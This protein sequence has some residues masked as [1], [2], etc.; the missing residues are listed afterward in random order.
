MIR[1]LVIGILFFLLYWLQ[2][3][4]YKHL[5]QK[6]LT[7]SVSF[8]KNR[9]FQGEQGELQEIIENKKHLPLA[10]LKVKFRA[11]RN[12]AFG[13]EKGSR[14]TD[15]FY[16]NDVFRIGGGERVIR[17]L[18][19]QGVRRGYYTIESADLVAADLL[20][21]TSFIHTTPVWTELYVYPR[22]YDSEELR[23]SLVRLSGEVLTKRQ[24]LED[25]FEYRGIREYL[26]FDSM[27]TINWKATAKTGELKVNR[28]NYTSPKHVRVFFSIQDDGS[29]MKD[30]RVEATLSIVTG[31]CSSFLS[32]GLQVSCYGNGRD[33]KTD[34]YV[35]VAPKAGDAQLDL[36]Y[37]TLAR[38]DTEKPPADFTDTFR[39]RLMAHM[40]D[41][42]TCIVA[43]DRPDDL[44]RL[45]KDYQD[46]GRDYRW[47]YPVS[48]NKLPP[49]PGEFKGHVQFIHI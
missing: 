25:P 16:R 1:L 13:S 2:L 45:I 9:I 18:K 40:G 41:I 48:D 15:Q 49:L 34:Q 31:L 12:L 37:R 29:R 36:I 20:L 22:P 35:C 42:I 33:I 44:I 30:E 19:F 47:F 3:L 21:T 46:S 24:L 7:V 43:S 8:L 39:D 10:M 38:V 11:S 28:K 27:R 5:W 6:K 23:R 4:A 26:P 32:Q 17:T 14:T